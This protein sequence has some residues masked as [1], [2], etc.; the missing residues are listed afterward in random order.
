M[1]GGPEPSSAGNEGTKIRSTA[2]T[3]V[4][5]GVEE[6]ACVGTKNTSADSAGPRTLAEYGR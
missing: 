6:A 3:E 4:D 2:H 1:G 5:T